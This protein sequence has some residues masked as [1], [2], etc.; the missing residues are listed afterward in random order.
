[1]ISAPNV[2]LHLLQD[3]EADELL[4]CSPLA[5]PAGVL[6]TPQASTDGRSPGS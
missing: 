6:L 4:D 5:A 2:T 1:M 3:A